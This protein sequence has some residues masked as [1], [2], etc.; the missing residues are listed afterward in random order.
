MSSNR[1]TGL[2]EEALTHSVIRAF[3]DVHRELGFGFR[4]YIYTLALERDLVAVR[5]MSSR[6]DQRGTRG[7]S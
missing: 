2:V 6:N 3:Y 1:E 4:E 5:W 7:A